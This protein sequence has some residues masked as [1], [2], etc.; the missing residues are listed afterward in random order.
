MREFTAEAEDAGE[1][2]DLVV[3]SKYPQFTRSALG[4]L[5]ENKMVSVK[6]IPTKPAYRVQAGDFISVDETYLN[7]EPPPIGL[8]VIYEDDD[9][10]VIDKPA[11]ILTHSKGALNLEP[12]VASFIS[13]KLND[14]KLSG[15]RAGIVHRLDRPTSGVMVAAKNHKALIFFQKQFSN[16][17]VRKTYIA[18]VV[19]EIEPPEAIIDIPIARNPKKPQT[20]TVSPAGKSALTIYKR[21]KSFQKSGKSYSLIELK[22]ETGRTHQLRVHLA[23]IGHPI[24][25]DRIYGQEKDGL[26]L[27]ASSLELTLPSGQRKIFKA[28]VPE[29]ITEFAGL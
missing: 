15:N 18:V 10:V 5:F 22:P 17:K 2:L 6:N 21:I 12:S 1:R 23:H 25:G 20:F 29:R 24:V 27:H 9:I 4:R 28:P 14:G 13:L 3:A 11:G 19:G 16:K 7:S 8:P 26:M